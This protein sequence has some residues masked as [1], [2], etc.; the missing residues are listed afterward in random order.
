[1]VL[2]FTAIN[3]NGGTRVGTEVIYV[4]SCL[5]GI[6]MQY[7]RPTYQNNLTAVEHASYITEQRLERV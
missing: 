5:V 1:M 4:C 3:P 2:L 6:C 7:M